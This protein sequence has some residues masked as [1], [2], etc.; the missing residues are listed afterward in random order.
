MNGYFWD[1]TRP[2]FRESLARI[3][4]SWGWF[5][6]AGILYILLGIAAFVWPAASTVGLTFA[7]GVVFVVSGIIQLVQAIQLL[8]EAGSGWRFFH[9][10]VSLAA[11]ILIWRYP[12]GGMVGIAIAMIFYFFASAAIRA[13]AAF[14]LRPHRGWGWMLMGAIASL[15]LGVE[16][17]ATFPVSALWVPGL[18]LGIDLVFYGSALIGFSFDL[19]NVHRGLEKATEQENKIGRAA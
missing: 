13:S 6:V 15:V 16:M 8:R 7:L 2:D 12:A 17:I 1:S 4:H 5:L 3:G 10:I 14:A 19:K 11:G 9:A 18:I